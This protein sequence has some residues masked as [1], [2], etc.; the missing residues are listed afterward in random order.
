MYTLVTYLCCNVSLPAAGER[1][2]FRGGEIPEHGL[3]VLTEIDTS[4]GETLQCLTDKTDCCS[5]TEGSW[6]YPNGSEISTGSDSQ[7]YV[8]RGSGVVRLHRKPWGDGTEGIYQCKIPD[9]R[10]TLQ[11]LLVGLYPPDNG[12]SD[13]SVDTG[14]V[15]RCT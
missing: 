15:T 3:A 7:M 2:E 11:N 4:E 5:A 9:G 12:R 13:S 10:G 14:I 1:I 8:T 6:L